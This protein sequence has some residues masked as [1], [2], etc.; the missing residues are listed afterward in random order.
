[1]TT[2]EKLTTRQRELL[3]AIPDDGAWHQIPIYTAGGTILAL[4][5]KGLIELRPKNESAA[6]AGILLFLSYQAAYVAK[7]VTEQKRE[8]RHD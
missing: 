3:N 6:R 4:K 2:T 8:V 1:M 7:R 5:R